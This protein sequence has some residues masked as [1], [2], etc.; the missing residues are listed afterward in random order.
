MDFNFPLLKTGLDVQFRSF[1]PRRAF[2]FD[3]TVVSAGEANFQ[4]IVLHAGHSF[5]LARNTYLTPYTGFVFS[6]MSLSQAEEERLKK[7]DKSE[8]SVGYPVGANLDYLFFI[9][10]QDNREFHAGFGLRL[11]FA[12]H[13]GDWEDMESGLGKQ[14]AVLGLKVFYAT[15]GLRND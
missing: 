3:D 9:P 5:R 15:G 1:S 7:K 12:W 10:G 14:G 13:Y 2:A 11:A 4:R 8:S 6:E